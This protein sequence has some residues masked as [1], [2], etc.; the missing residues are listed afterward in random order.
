MGM[1][2]PTSGPPAMHWFMGRRKQG[3]SGPAN[4]GLTGD[5]GL[6]LPPEPEGPKDLRGRWQN[7][8]QSV[9]GT[10]AAL[11]R[12]LRLV[13]DAS[14]AT[15]L[16][17]FAT[18][19]IAGVIPAA[20]AYISKLLINSVVQGILIHNTHSPDRVQFSVGPL[21]TPVFTAVGMIVFLAVLQ[22]ALFALTSLLST[23]R[24]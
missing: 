4:S 9:T 18:T 1:M 8:K 22:L 13:W 7:L 14:P 3:D 24:N 20:A 6:E 16:T 10:T 11:P 21:N 15:T 23:I 2:P 17:L 5:P 12:V 19:A